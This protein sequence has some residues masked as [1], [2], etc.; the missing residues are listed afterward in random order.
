[1]LDVTATITLSQLI[2]VLSKMVHK[3]LI[4]I[5]KVSLYSNYLMVATTESVAFNNEMWCDS[6]VY[7]HI[8]IFL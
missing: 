7:I 6:Y 4:Y 8:H 3:V 1:M 5:F 2:V